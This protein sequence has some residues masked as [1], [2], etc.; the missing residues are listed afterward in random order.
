MAFLFFTLLFI[1]FSLIPQLREMGPHWTQ[2]SRES[3]QVRW[4]S[5]YVR[6][7]SPQVRESAMSTYYSLNSSLLL[8]T[9]VLRS[10]YHLHMFYLHSFFFYIYCPNIHAYGYRQVT[11]S[12]LAPQN[13]N[14]P[15]N[16]RLLIV[17]IVSVFRYSLNP[18][19]KSS[20]LFYDGPTC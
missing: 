6:W 8:P 13:S 4:R 10:T 9:F 3:P 1:Y 7:E 17:H 2:A 14:A 18:A 12:Q 15:Q 11:L 5:P 20:I 16:S 19:Q